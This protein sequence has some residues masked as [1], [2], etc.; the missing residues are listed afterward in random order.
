LW[1]SFGDHQPAIRQNNIVFCFAVHSRPTQFVYGKINCNL[2]CHTFPL[3]GCLQQQAPC[4]ACVFCCTVVYR[5]STLY[6]Y[7]PHS[8][9]PGIRQLRYYR[10]QGQWHYR[11]TYGHSGLLTYQCLCSPKVTRYPLSTCRSFPMQNRAY[12]TCAP[13]S[14]CR[15][16]FYV[17]PTAI[18]ITLPSTTGP[19]VSYGRLLPRP[20]PGLWHPMAFLI[21]NK[22]AVPGTSLSIL[23][24]AMQSLRQ[25]V[26]RCGG[27]YARPY[28]MVPS[29]AI[30]TQVYVSQVLP[31]ICCTRYTFLRG[32]YAPHA[33]V[34]WH[35]VPSPAVATP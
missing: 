13:R 14:T 16:I 7:R 15:N 19:M 11:I 8:Q 24:V 31:S 4:L 10:L 27:S 6:L 20:T 35:T 21:R 23:P 22:I 2:I 3:V 32:T 28:I 1:E 29:P 33:P 26:P 34:L 12:A 25:P 30:A 17:E 9:Y 5:W 18:S